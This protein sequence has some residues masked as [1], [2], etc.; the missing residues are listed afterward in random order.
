M[1]CGQQDKI[2]DQKIEAQIRSY[3]DN[4]YFKNNFTAEI[5]ELKINDVQEVKLDSVVQQI[6]KNEFLRIAALI[7]DPFNNPEDFDFMSLT[8]EAMDQALETSEYKSIKDRLT[9][10][11]EN[12]PNN[13]ALSIKIY[14]KITATNLNTDKK[15]NYLWENIYFLLD[16]RF[17]MINDPIVFK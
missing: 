11:V 1:S 12:S 4:V 6:L 13:I 9:K 17:S 14:V 8:T 3:I 10:N 5:I 7:V 16:E 2:N 15:K